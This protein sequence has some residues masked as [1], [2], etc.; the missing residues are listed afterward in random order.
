MT[1]VLPI[2]LKIIKKIYQAIF[3]IFSKFPDLTMFYGSWGFT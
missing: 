1:D 2:F 3:L